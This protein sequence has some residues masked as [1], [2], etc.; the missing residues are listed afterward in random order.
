MN[1][2]AIK[3]HFW[4]VWKD[5]RVIISRT[6]DGLLWVSDISS[7]FQQ[8]ETAPVFESRKVFPTIPEAGKSITLGNGCPESNGPDIQRLLDNEAKKDIQ[9]LKVT[10]YFVSACS[11]FVRIFENEKGEKIYID[12]NYLDLLTGKYEAVEQYHYFGQGPFDTVLVRD[13]NDQLVALIM[14]VKVN[15]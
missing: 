8:P 7:L 13:S 12:K 1:E 14:P 6:N 2:L 5:G 15:N 10:K 11:S 9:P 3:K 4:K